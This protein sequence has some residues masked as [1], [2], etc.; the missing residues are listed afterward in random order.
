LRA[1]T[2]DGDGDAFWAIMPIIA[3][4]MVEHAY[5]LDYGTDRK[6]YIDDYLGNINWQVAGE[7][8]MNVK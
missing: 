7:R 4:D 6:T 5:L 2:A 3:I 1:Y 8:Y